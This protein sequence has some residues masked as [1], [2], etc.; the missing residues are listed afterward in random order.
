MEFELTKTQ[1]RYF[2]L[3]EDTGNNYFLNGEPGT[4][5][6]V[7]LR[8]LRESGR[9]V[10]WVGAPTGLA[11]TNAG[12][13]TIHSIF[14]IPVSEGIIDP[15]FN[16]FTSDNATVSHLRYNVRHLLIDEISMVRA[17]TLDY[18]DRMLK[19]I[20]QN[21]EPFGG[22]QVIVV[23]DFF[24]LPPIVKTN[25]K[26]AMEEAGY[27]TP[28]A[29]S[30][31][32]WQNI[33]TLTL[34]E[35]L[36]QKGD[37]KFIDLLRSIRT[38]DVSAKQMV[39]LNDRVED[40]PNHITAR[41]CATNDQTD[42]INNKY[43]NAIPAEEI[44]FEAKSYGKW[45]ALP[46]DQTLRLKVGAQVMVRQNK[47]DRPPDHEG[48]FESD[49]VN[50]TLGVV[51]EIRTPQ[52]STEDDLKEEIDSD[53]HV[54]IRLADGSI[55]RIFVKTWERKIKKKEGDEWIEVVVA[56]FEQMPISLAWAISMHKSQGQ[57]FD[58]VHIDGSKIFAA[59]QFYVALSRCQ[60]F[61]GVTLQ[62]RINMKRI[63]ADKRVIEYFNQLENV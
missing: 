2:D 47:A 14:R 29:F 34:T 4:G 37:R 36:R 57:T 44:I 52:Q 39:L 30:A 58:A 9:K 62:T 59:G 20:K 26:K 24:Q 61:D 31:K 41:L 55:R 60:S 23:G 46:A 1:Q 33:Q 27:E 54:V 35:V 49:V 53:P 42:L 13:R 6:S 48:P 56:S 11:A 17:D 40:T 15:T 63:Y 38:G 22:V 43:L 5:K 51:Q 7:L 50:G 21:E 8:A 45:D 3:I 19:Y 18:I 12:G 32:C 25:E 28:F 10:W 16:N